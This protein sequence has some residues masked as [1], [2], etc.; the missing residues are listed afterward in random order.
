MPLRAARRRL[1]AP[2]PMPK[3]SEMAERSRASSRQCPI[4]LRFLLICTLA[5]A[6]SSDTPT[7]GKS[8]PPEEKKAKALVR[9]YT[10]ANAMVDNAK[11]C[12]PE[13][14]PPNLAAC[15]RACELNHSN[16]CANWAALESAKALALYQRA[17]KGGSGIGCEG[18]ATLVERSGEDATAIYLNARRY[19]RIH[20]SQGYARSCDQLASLFETT[21]GGPIMLEAAESFRQQACVLG[22]KSSC[23]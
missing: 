21:K 7:S 12:E 10:N 23:R 5:V 16:S 11:L 20:C 15:A 3:N 22:R 4:R 9:G 8:E 14:A 17:C 2:S 1:K 13:V 6:C 19:H 18:A